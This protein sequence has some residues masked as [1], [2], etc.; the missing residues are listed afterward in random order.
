MRKTDPSVAMLPTVML[1]L[2]CLLWAASFVAI[3]AAVG[4]YDPVAVNFGRLAIASLLFLGMLPRLRRQV[5]RRADL[6]WLVG[7]ALFEPCLYGVFEAWGL[8]LTTASQA[9]MVASVLPL[10]VAASAGLLLGERLPVR[11]WKGMACALAG[12]VWLSLAGRPTEAAPD[13]A[14]GNFLEFLAMCSATGYVLLVRRL[15]ARYSPLF[16]TAVQAWVGAAFFAPA[17]CWKLA[18]TGGLP[19]DPAA[20]LAVVYLGAG[21]SLGAYALYNAGVA[22]LGAAQATVFINLIPVMALGLGMLLLG[23]TLTGQQ[24]LASAVILAGVWLSRPNRGPD[25]G[26]DRGPA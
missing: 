17:F 2:A 13:P 21:A 26:P 24:W 14:L 3:K 22:A 10:L 4:V 15:S 18:A 12:V 20:F 9:G 1:V 19:W 11:A 7:M 5:V 8:T 23:E 6:P 16:L 25:S